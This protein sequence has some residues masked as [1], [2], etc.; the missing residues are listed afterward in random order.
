MSI[1]KN[2]AETHSKK[3]AVEKNIAEMRANQIAADEEAFELRFEA[4]VKAEILP[5]FN[6]LK[7]E[8][9]TEGYQAD[10]KFGRD[11]NNM[12][13]VDL[14][15]IPKKLAKVPN[16]EVEGTDSCVFRIKAD[17]QA[18]SI[19]W[20]S[21][22]NQRLGGLSGMRQGKFEFADLKQTKLQSHVED[23]F[24]KSFDAFE[25]R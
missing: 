18:K 9:V 15:F 23:F 10:V 5:F 17:K 19:A 1:F 22:F 2:V 6:T 3:V 20:I 4:T 13:S 11:G 7:T 14:R 8:I 25:K 12:L 16:I 24:T 21:F